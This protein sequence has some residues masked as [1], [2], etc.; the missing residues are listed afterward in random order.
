[1]TVMQTQGKI[2]FVPFTALR[3][4]KV[5]GLGAE[6]ASSRAGTPYPAMLKRLQAVS[7]FP[8]GISPD[9]QQRLIA[10]AQQSE[11]IIAR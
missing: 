7:H 2:M 6:Y 4:F 9:L 1:M 3:S 8:Q 10:H 11:I 5:D